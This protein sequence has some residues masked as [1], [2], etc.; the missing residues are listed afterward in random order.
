MNILSLI[1]ESFFPQNRFVFVTI[2]S[3]L[4]RLALIQKK[5]KHFST[6]YSEDHA[7]DQTV[8]SQDRIFGIALLQNYINNFAEQYEP[9]GKVII[10]SPL[11]QT[12]NLLSILQLALLGGK[13][14]LR[15]MKIVNL[16]THLLLDP[17]ALDNLDN[18]PNYLAQL[19]PIKSVISL[20]YA[21]RQV[22]VLMVLLLITSI[23]YGLKRVEER[24]EQRFYTTLKNQRV[25]IRQLLQLKDQLRRLKK[26][27]SLDPLDPYP[28]F[29]FLARSIDEH[30]WLDSVIYNYEEKKQKE[31]SLSTQQ[32]E[33]PFCITGYSSNPDS[34]TEL[35]KNCMQHIRKNDISLKTK[36]NKNQ[37]IHYVDATYHFVIKGSVD[38]KDLEI[39]SDWLEKQQ[40]ISAK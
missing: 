20:E 1:K 32:K 16:G 4:I 38:A 31:S 6:I 15:L 11:A 2:Q 14:Q 7:L 3:G 9:A 27:R 10:N 33:V 35:V 8:I 5:K 17:N 29:E 22:A 25:E 13:T 30:S 37:K 21:V 39:I 24:R 34:A 28:F 40:K 26:G 12:G 36:R 23:G 19:G 18:T